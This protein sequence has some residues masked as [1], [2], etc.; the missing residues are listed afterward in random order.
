MPWIVQPR[1]PVC[2][3]AQGCPDCL[4]PEAR[5]RAFIMNR[6]AVLYD[7]T[8][9]AWIA[10]YKYGGREQFVEP[11]SMMLEQAYR[12]MCRELAGDHEAPIRHLFSSL[13]RLMSG[14]PQWNVDLITWVPVSRERLEERGFNQAELLARKLAKRLNMPACEMLVRMTHTGKQSFKKRAERLHNL[15]GAFGLLPNLDPR[16]FKQW[17]FIGSR[18]HSE[19]SFPIK[20]LLVDD[21]YTTGTTAAVCSSVLKRLEAAI[22]RSVSIYSLTLARS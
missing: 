4:R 8:M 20:I 1:C 6:S 14:R 3:R 21:I 18:E 19:G 16:F 7:T 2:G 13:T 10:E 12:Q 15:D 22:G 9:R 11:F 5:S 17:D